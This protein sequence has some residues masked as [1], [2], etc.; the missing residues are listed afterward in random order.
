MGA[1][2]GSQEEF[3]KR[4]KGSRIGQGEKLNDSAVTSETCPI[5]TWSRDGHSELSY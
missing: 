5:G 2:R 1:G 3:L 4:S